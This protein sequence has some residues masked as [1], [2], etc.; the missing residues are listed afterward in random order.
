MAL[1]DELLA[2]QNGHREMLPLAQG[3][4]LQREGA[5]DAGGTPP[6]DDHV[7]AGPRR[8]QPSATHRGYARRRATG[9]AS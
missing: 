4:T 9:A 3:G 7:A 5:R 2:F 8:P 6:K 1:A